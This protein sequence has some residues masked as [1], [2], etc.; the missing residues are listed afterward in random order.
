MHYPCYLVAKIFLRPFQLLLHLL[1]I[2]S[3]SS[4]SFSI[5]DLTLARA[6]K[7][8]G[9]ALEY[10]YRTFSAPVYSLALRIC[11][12]TADAEDI[13]QDTFI[14]LFAK[15]NQYRGDAPFWAWLRRIAINTTLMRLRRNKRFMSQ[16]EEEKDYRHEGQQESDHPANLHDLEKILT[17]L[18]PAARTVIWLHDIEGYTHAEIGEL[19]GKTPSFS[20]SQ[21]SRAHQKLRSKLTWQTTQHIRTHQHC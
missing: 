8:D 3:N 14:E 19:M 7:G 11:A 10:L 21:L 9:E 18:S 6:R 16:L 17:T 12:S 15:L 2:M 1:N 5:D 4:F 13:T 20:K